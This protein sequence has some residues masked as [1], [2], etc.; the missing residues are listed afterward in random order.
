MYTSTTTENHSNLTFIVRGVEYGDVPIDP[1]PPNP[2]IPPQP[3]T[4][5]HHTLVSTRMCACV[6]VPLDVRVKMCKQSDEY[7]QIKAKL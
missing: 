6:G 1:A 7:Q 4:H 5:T 3:H 2:H